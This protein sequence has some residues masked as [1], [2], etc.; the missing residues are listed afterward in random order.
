M[1][2]PAVK[3][4]QLYSI[5]FFKDLDIIFE[6]LRLLDIDVLQHVATSKKLGNV[7]LVDKWL[8]INTTEKT[9]FIQGCNLNNSFYLVNKEGNGVATTIHYTCS[10][11]DILT[12]IEYLYHMYKNL[13]EN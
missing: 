3:L 5:N 11:H 9:I 2:C 7:Q 8:S 4:H 10:D 6:D 13:V 12:G 1:V